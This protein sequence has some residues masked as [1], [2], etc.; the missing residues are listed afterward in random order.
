MLNAAV[1]VAIVCVHPTFFAKLR[2]KA[3]AEVRAAVESEAVVLIYANMGF[4]FY[5]LVLFNY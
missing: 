2:E 1:N 4:Y 3:E 5:A